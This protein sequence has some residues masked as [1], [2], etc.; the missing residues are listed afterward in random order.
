MTGGA[1]NYHG[2]GV[3][4]SAGIYLI[5]GNQGTSVDS[6]AGLVV[7]MGGAT[8]AP[9]QTVV[10]VAGR[11]LARDIATTT[12]YGLDYIAGVNGQNNVTVYGARTQPV[13]T[14]GAGNT[15]PNY[16]GVVAKGGILI[17][18]AVTNWYG[19]K[20]EGSYIGTNRLP[21][22]EDVAKTGDASGNRFRSNTQFGSTAGSFGGGDGVIG[23][24][25][26]QALPSSNPSGGGVL[27]ADFGALKWR[28]SAG[29]VTI[30][31]PA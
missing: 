25:N 23:I 24:A 1:S 18:G 2:I 21:F 5:L 4:R 26:A 10:G 3:N 12:A 8:S 27:Y 28:G 22:Y 17:S 11:A 31:A 29:T 6:R 20:T 16:Y 7:D 30:I 19:F 9:G 15:V 14:A 13:I